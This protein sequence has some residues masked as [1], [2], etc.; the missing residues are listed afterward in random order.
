MV[1]IH[2]II[3]TPVSS[4]CFLIIREKTNEC[5]IVDPG[6]Y[7]KN[8][9]L[10]TFIG[11]NNLKICA[12]VLTHEHFDHIAGVNNLILNFKFDLICSTE[13]AAGIKNSR[14]NLSAYNDQLA[15]IEIT[16]SPKIVHDRQEFEFADTRLIFIYTPGHS[17]GSMCF[18]IDNYFFS[19][20]TILLNH[21]TRLNLPGSNRKLFFESLEKIKSIIKSGMQIFPGHGDCFEFDSRFLNTN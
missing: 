1:S 17:P 20:D 8:D 6:S 14:K 18:S 4:N 3:N 12:V 10:Y 19:G 21:K 5:I 9:C 16:I 15:P 11:E 13:G 7:E 2:R